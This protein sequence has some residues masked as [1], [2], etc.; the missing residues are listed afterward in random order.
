MTQFLKNL[1]MLGA[2]LAFLAVSGADWALS[3]G[4]GVF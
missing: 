4:V 3:A 2:G 1:V